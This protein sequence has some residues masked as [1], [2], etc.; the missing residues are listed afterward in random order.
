MSVILVWEEDAKRSSYSFCIYYPSPNI[1]YFCSFVK[2]QRQIYFNIGHEIIISPYTRICKVKFEK[3]NLLI[4]MNDE[5]M[6]EHFIKT[7]TLDKLVK[8]MKF[9]TKQEPLHLTDFIG[10]SPR[11]TDYPIMAF[12]DLHSFLNE[13]IVEIPLD[14]V[15]EISLD[16]VPL[17]LLNRKH[18]KI[19]GMG[20][21]I[22]KYTY[23]PNEYDSIPFFQVISKSA[24]SLKNITIR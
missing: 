24:N 11:I 10:H 1:P 8:Q 16:G 19:G 17:I 2:H 7:A 12:I 6:Y 21:I 4:K 18:A 9:L 23:S 15:I 14:E 22:E 5:Q 13:K 20:V 3:E